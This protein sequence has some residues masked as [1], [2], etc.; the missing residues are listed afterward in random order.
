M[1][2]PLRP[3]YPTTRPTPYIRYSTVIA[4]CLNQFLSMFSNGILF[5]F[6]LYFHETEKSYSKKSQE[7]KE[8]HAL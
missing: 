3:T 2:G 4:F 7:K 5:P 8:R 6:L 1:T